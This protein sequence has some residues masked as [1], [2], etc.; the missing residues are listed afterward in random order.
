MRIIFPVFCSLVLV[1]FSGCRNTREA[2]V[3]PSPNIVFLFADDQRYQTIHRLGNP[4]IFTANLD[5]LTER[6][7]TFTNT[8]IMGGTSGAVC[9]PSRAMLLTGKTLFH[10]DKDGEWNYPIRAAD[11][12]FVELLRQHGYVTYGIGKQHN[13]EAVVARSF[14]DGGHFM[15]GGMS[16]HYDIP[17]Y[18]FNADSNYCDDKKYRVLDKHSTDLYADDAVNFIESYHGEAPFLLYLAFQAPHDPREMPEKYLQLYDNRDIKLPP[19]F[20]PRHPFDNGELEIRDEQL[21]SFPRTGEEILGHIRAYYAMISHLDDA[22]GRIM[23]AI[24]QK[25]LSDNTLIIFSADNGLAVGQHG[26]MGKQNVYE[27]S[28]KIPFIISGPGIPADETRDAFCYLN[29]LYPTLCDYL[30]IRIPVTVEARSF[31]A[32]IDNPGSPHREFLTFAYKDFQRGFRK[33]NWKYIE[34]SVDD[35]RNVQLFNLAEDP[36]ETR[37]LA[38]EPGNQSLMEDLRKDLIN[39]WTK[40]GDTGNF[41]GDRQ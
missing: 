21:A 29:D 15:F 37:N 19:N 36:Y 22:I 9:A 4:E 25:G 11:T 38:K 27:H 6:G 14:T 39:E 7:I 26:L 41:W 12:T 3:A 2:Q 13:G 31:L 18:D 28:I 5:Q 8:Y 40:L 20:L 23:T 24:D 10:L 35:N 17:V 30:G 33:G 16:S 1:I 32:C 34:Y